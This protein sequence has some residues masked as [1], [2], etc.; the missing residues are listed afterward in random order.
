MVTIT[1]VQ[2]RTIRIPLNTPVTFSTRSVAQ[3]FYTLV[4]IECSDGSHGIGFCHGG[5]RFGDLATLAVREL[6]RPNM[7]GQDPHRT[8]GIWND[9]YQDALL[10]GRAGSVMRALSAVDIALWDRNARATGLPL[11]RYLGAFE[12]SDVAA[13]ASGGYY[14]KGG[15]DEVT[16]E[17][18]SHVA[19]GF[20]AAKMK[21]GGVSPE[22]DR[23][24]VAAAR[25]VLGED[26][27]LLLDAN[28]A[29]KDLGSALRALEP[30]LPYR[31][32]FI[33]EPFAPEDVENHRRLAERI[34][35]PVATGEIVGGR[36]AHRDL[37]ER[38]GVTVLQA[39]AAVC[40]GVTEW[41]RIAGMAA[42]QSVP[43][44]PHSFHDLHIHLVASCPNGLFVEYFKDDKVLPF[45]HVLD[46]QIEARNGRLQL[47]TTP[48]LGFG[49]DAASVDRF[50]VNSW[51]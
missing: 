48:G 36:W 1:S 23:Q 35:V 13:Y 38:G 5:N 6:F 10:N 16:A 40:G 20:T 4:R 21:I 26:G 41:R 24:R 2:S 37:L 29:W 8:E 30:L 34:G 33:E 19:D 46:T 15:P 9:L 32:Y 42:S 11:W 27:I 49:F 12:R 31:P 51:E 44:A 50:A 25:D 18:A 14:I 22:A 47:P 3:R 28:N 7:I 39:D 43:M 45:R 17:M